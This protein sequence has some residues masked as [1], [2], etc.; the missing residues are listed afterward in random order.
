MSSSDVPNAP[1]PSRSNP[2]WWG[3]VVTGAVFGAAVVAVAAYLLMPGMMLMT[4]P[5]RLSFDQTVTEIE[6][7][8]DEQ[9]WESPGTLDMQKSLGKH[10]VDFAHRVKVIQLCK[11][12]YAADVLKTD[13]YVSCLMPCTIAVWEDDAGRV[14][15][16]KMNTG[17]MGK[18]FG[19]NIARVMGDHVAAEEHAMLESVLAH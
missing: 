15:V 12:K 3:G 8:I 16:S 11:P 9:G 7:A 17:L 2:R 13:R 5:S 18:L 14:F 6:H 1:D 19:G 4:E 10:E